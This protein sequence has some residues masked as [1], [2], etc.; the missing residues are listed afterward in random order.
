M[1]RTIVI[2][3]GIIV[4]IGAGAAIAAGIGT[5]AVKP[6]AATLAVQSSVQKQLQTCGSENGT[7][8]SG[9]VEA[10]ATATSSEPSLNGPARLMLTGAI[11]KGR[12]AGTFGGTLRID[13]A[14]GRDTLATFAGVYANG[15]LH[16]LLAGRARK[17]FERLIANMSADLNPSTG[18]LSNIKIGQTDGSGGA[19][20]LQPG[21][22]TP[23]RAVKERVDVTGFVTAVSRD[24]ITVAG[25]TCFSRDAKPV[26]GAPAIIREGDRVRMSCVFEN[27]RLI[28]ERV[29]RLS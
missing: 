15:E 28:V 17:P 25:V 29:K 11:D 2:A 22:C 21:N 3:T 19:V 7:L 8:V 12:N 13:V 26:S 9:T 4:L 1:K 6:T 10:R 24:S 27:E 14:S 18:Q 5:K 20:L 16:G 23:R